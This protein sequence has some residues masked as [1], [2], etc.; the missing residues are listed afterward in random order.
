MLVDGLKLMVIGMGTV[1]TFLAIMVMVISWS[2]RLLAPYAGLLAETTA[3]PAPRRQAP[4]SAGSAAD[5][6]PV[7]AIVAAV[8][9]YRQEHRD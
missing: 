5:A 3:K 4:K 7:A 8:H 6:A 1:F 2:A 9:Q